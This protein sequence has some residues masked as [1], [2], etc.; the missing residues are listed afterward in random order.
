VQPKN[1]CYTSSIR[2]G[3]SEIREIRGTILLSHF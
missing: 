3:G 1:A 2:I